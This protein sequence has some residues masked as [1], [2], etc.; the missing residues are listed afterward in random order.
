LNSFKD[1]IDYFNESLEGH[2]N[3]DQLLMRSFLVW[4]ASQQ[5]DH[6]ESVNGI[7]DNSQQSIVTF[8]GAEGDG[9]TPDAL[10]KLLKTNKTTVTTL[11]IH[12]VGMLKHSNKENKNCGNTVTWKP[13]TVRHWQHAA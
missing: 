7:N 8:D 10:V 12:Y 2:A 11:F 3:K 9:R 4:L 13:Y 6:N 1:L 5:E